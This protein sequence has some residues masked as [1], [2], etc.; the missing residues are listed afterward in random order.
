MRF[1][2]NLVKAFLSLGRRGQHNI[3]KILCLSVGL[4]V[5]SVLIAKVYIEQRYDTF[6]SNWDR[7]YIISEKIFQNGKLERLL[8][9]GHLRRKIYHLIKR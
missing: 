1:F 8:L 6:F 7:T 9:N 2:N 4:A 5:G 3:V